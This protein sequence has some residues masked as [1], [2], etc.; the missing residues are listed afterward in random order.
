MKTPIVL[1]TCAILSLLRIDRDCIL[2]NSLLKI[3]NIYISPFV[4]DKELYY[5]I[6]HK[7]FSKEQTE[8]I[9]EE[10]N[11][12]LPK[13]II[14]R[15]DSFDN[16]WAYNIRQYVNYSKK[17]NGEL[18]SSAYALRISR[19]EECRVCF[20]TD[21]ICAKE[22]FSPFFEFQ[23]IGYI[24]DS[25]DLLILLYRLVQEF[26]LDNLKY[27][28]RELYNEYS[29]SFE[30]F[31]KIVVDNQSQWK[32]NKT[33][34][35]K[36]ISNISNL[37]EACKNRDVRAIKSILSFFEGDTKYKY[38]FDTLKDYSNSIT[39][40]YMCRKIHTIIQ[41]LNKGNIVYKI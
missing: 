40:G 21:D 23:Q 13:V 25:V 8:C 7:D 41:S 34:D 20:Y 33:R 35:A 24:C 30:N 27:F 29:I 38:I 31:S 12:L 16:E 2:C 39:E 26:S 10:L 18:Y 28:I 19:E 32:K 15:D 22:Q 17:N 11:I 5:V 37:E 4:H 36:L 3:P 14:D 6:E 1:D 9:Y